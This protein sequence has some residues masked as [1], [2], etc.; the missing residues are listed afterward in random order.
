MRNSSVKRML[1]IVLASTMLLQMSAPTVYAN[2]EASDSIVMQGD[3]VLVQESEDNAEQSDIAT[4]ET[5]N[6]QAA[7][8]ETADQNTSEETETSN[9]PEGT[10]FTVTIN[11][12]GGHLPA[13]WIKTANGV[14]EDLETESGT[15]DVTEQED[16]TLVVKVQGRSSLSLMNPTSPDTSKYF[17]GWECNTG[18]VNDENSVLTF[19]GS[20]TEYTLTA[21][22][23]DV[24]SESDKVENART[25]TEITEQEDSGAALFA[26][27]P[28]DSYSKLELA[29][30]GLEFVYEDGQIQTFT[31]PYDGDYV[32]TAFGANGGTGRAEYAGY[33]VPGRGG[34][35][36]ATVTLKA[37][38]TIYMHIGEAGGDWST[39]R[40]FGGGGAGC[41]EEHAWISYDDNSL[42]IF[43]RGGGATYVSV[44]NFD[45]ANAGQ[46]A[47]DFTAEQQS[48]NDTA[49]AEAKK[50]IIMLAAGGGGA[51]EYGSPYVHLGLSG[52]GYEGTSLFAPRHYQGIP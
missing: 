38:Q 23:E 29:M 45:M 21:C 13:E 31:A 20:T 32:I 2:N 39:E 34:M 17:S 35:T 15:L 6:D 8:A 26:L 30:E 28:S 24:V 48:Q 37:G 18:N 41:D 1:G 11:P 27:K 43:G 19:D 52:G 5:A 4:S 25:Y 7:T 51:G 49:A 46:A 33:G 3:P 14:H 36:E 40:T 47:Q 22:Y 12:N 44:D 9:I 42:H 50:H 10:V 16:G